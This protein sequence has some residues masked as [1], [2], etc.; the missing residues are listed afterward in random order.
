M[1]IWE[2]D[3]HRALHCH[4]P[5]TGGTSLTKWAIQN[6]WDVQHFATNIPGFPDHRP[7]SGRHP[8]Q[9]ATR[10]VSC[11][12]DY[13]EAFAVVRDPVERM[14]SELAQRGIAQDDAYAWILEQFEEHNAIMATVTPGNRAGRELAGWPAKYGMHIMPQTDFVPGGALI[15]FYEEDEVGMIGAEVLMYS[16]YDMTGNPPHLRKAERTK[17]DLPR[18]AER[19]VRDFYAADY[20]RFDFDNQGD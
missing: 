10:Y 11:A 15:C 4:V 16:V 9:H 3:G 17:Y 2:K 13:D 7:G 8:L 1:P 12:W 20:E 6:G 14:R 18:A 19:A 5:K